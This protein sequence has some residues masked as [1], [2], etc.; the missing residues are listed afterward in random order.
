[1]KKTKKY[2]HVKSGGLLWNDFATIRFAPL[3]GAGCT[4]RFVIYRIEIAKNHSVPRS[5]HKLAEETVFFLKGSGIAHVG[6]DKIAV[7]AGDSL[8]IPPG[9]PHGFITKASGLEIL[10]FLSPKVDDRTDFYYER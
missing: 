10:T 5:Y 3:A 1:M 6:R 9:I 4:D 2:R 7:A 8:F